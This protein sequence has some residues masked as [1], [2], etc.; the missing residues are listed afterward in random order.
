MSKPQKPVVVAV[1]TALAGGVA[2]AGS[3]FAITPLAQGYL[4]GAQQAQTAD[5]A[6][7]AEGSC[8]ADMKHAEGKC[9][10]GKCGMDKMDTDK[11]GKISKAE[12]VAAHDGKD[13]KFAA[14]D[15]NGDGFID[16]AEMKAHHEG[17]CGEGKCGSD[18]KTDAKAGG[19][20]GKCGEGKCGGAMD[21]KPA[22]KTTPAHDA[23]KGAVRNLK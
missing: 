23:P 6:K 4:L 2:L 21:A 15:T 7:D 12:F 19:M 18:M 5:A 13:D 9:G 17:K 20:E 14:H 1:C 10:E 8:G 16:A 3:A 11:D 22:A